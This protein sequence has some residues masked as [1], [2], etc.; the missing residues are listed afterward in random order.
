MGFFFFVLTVKF[1]CFSRSIV[2]KQILYSCIMDGY[3]LLKS[4]NKTNSSYKPEK[5]PV[6]RV[7]KT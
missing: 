6:R 4:S 7:G 2:V 1:L 5:L 3:R